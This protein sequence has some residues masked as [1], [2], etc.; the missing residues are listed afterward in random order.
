[1]IDLLITGKSS[2]IGGAVRERLAEFPEKYRVETIS[3][4]GDEW[5]KTGFAGYDA[6]LHAAGIAHIS[7]DPS[8]EEAYYRI[9][10]DLT[11]EIAKRA[12][13][14]GVK[15][16][17]FLSSM[18]VYGEASAAGTRARIH[19][20]TPPAPAN[21][22]GKSKLEAEKG[23]LALEGEGFK[24]TIIR[25]CM[26]YGKG[27]KG[28]YNALAKLAKRFPV[29]PKFVNER[30]V[31]Y[32]GNL[33]ECVRLILD[34]GMGGI[35]YPQDEK[36]VSVAELVEMIAEAHGKRKLFLRCLNP[37]VKLMGGRGIVRRA[38]GDMAYDPDMS[39]APGDYRRYTTKEA[40][41][42]TEE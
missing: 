28:N 13:A 9:N 21:A 10:R 30:S 16:F 3:V 32:A 17:I 4:R 31:L 35:F 5:K 38:F 6:L 22:Y 37:L 14:D 26:V 20:D 12:K 24:V 34:G 29:F 23:V 42:M 25:P 2:F 33:A 7:P 19:R 18:I 1:M 36:I 27:C 15:H 8:L 40:V 11:I 41:C 39:E